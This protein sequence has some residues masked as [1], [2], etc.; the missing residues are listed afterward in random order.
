MFALPKDRMPEAEVSLRLAFHIIKNKITNSPI[1]VAIDGAQV[2]VKNEII[3][4]PEMFLQD[5][6]WQKAEDDLKWQGVY[7]NSKYLNSIIIHSH[8]GEGDLI[9]ELMDGTNIHVECKKGPI[10]KSTSSA[11]YRL[12]REALGQLMTVDE[13]NPRTIYCIAVPG[14]DKFEELAVRWRKAPLIKRNNINIVTV[15]RTGEVKGFL[16]LDYE[17]YR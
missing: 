3:F 6:S 8:P 11:E 1:H 15:Y 17:M 9:T 16:K 13:E 5:N 12:I 10:I 4:D 2:K 14:T 7:K